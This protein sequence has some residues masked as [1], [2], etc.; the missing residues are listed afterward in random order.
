MSPANKQEARRP[1]ASDRIDG[2]YRRLDKWSDDWLIHR[3]LPGIVLWYIT[4]TDY[5]T[6]RTQT[7]M[8]GW[9]TQTQTQT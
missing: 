1:D 6:T 3:H 2:R 8:T 5:C 4:D 7:Q 9:V